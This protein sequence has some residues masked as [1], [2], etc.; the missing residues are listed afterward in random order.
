MK[1]S[2]FYDTTP[3]NPLKVNRRFGGTCFMLDS[4]LAYFSALKMKT[5]YFPDTSIDFQLTIWRYIPEDRTLFRYITYEAPQYAMFFISYYATSCLL[6]P[7]IL[8]CTCSETFQS[9]F[10]PRTDVS[11]WRCAGRMGP[12][13]CSLSAPEQRDSPRGLCGRVLPSPIVEHGFSVP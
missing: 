1:S 11:N 3:R 8:I 4:C 10:F 5:E 7:D 12:P 13:Q 2:I 9:T 6:D